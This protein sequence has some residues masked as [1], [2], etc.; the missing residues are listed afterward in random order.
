MLARAVAAELVSSELGGLKRGI[1]LVQAS[2]TIASYWLPHH[3]V[4]IRR[5]HPGIE[6]ALTIGNTAK[7]A[8]A[9][10]QGSAEL[11]FIE[12]VVNDLSLESRV[13][14]RDQLVTVVGPDHL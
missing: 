9:I 2:Q 14:A 3:L 7:A 10:Q 12:S 5:A 1:L 13:V 8:A 6:I 4:A 11:G